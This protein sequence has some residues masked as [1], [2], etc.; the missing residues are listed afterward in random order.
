MSDYEEK[1]LMKNVKLTIPWW[2]KLPIK[3]SNQWWDDYEV[4]SKLID[5]INSLSLNADK[6]AEYLK[7][8]FW[9]KTGWN[10]NTLEQYNYIKRK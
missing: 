4:T 3:G 9:V 6:T 5:H 7:I 1:K 8:G 2:D 10:K